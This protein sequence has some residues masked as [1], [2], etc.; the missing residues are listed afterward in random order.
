MRYDYCLCGMW[1][2]CV[3]LCATRYVQIYGKTTYAI[4]C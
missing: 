2:A 3:L 4:T 1:C